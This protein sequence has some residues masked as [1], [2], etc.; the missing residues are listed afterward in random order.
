MDDK[1]AFY[2]IRMLSHKTIE[3]MV[4]AAVRVRSQTQVRVS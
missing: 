2:V 3:Q 4:L 1:V